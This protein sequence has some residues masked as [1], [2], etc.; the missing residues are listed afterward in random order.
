MA[1]LTWYCMCATTFSRETGELDEVAFRLFLQ[2]IVDAKLGVYLGSAG[3]GEGHAL[4]RD[5]LRRVYQIG[6]EVC[7]GKVP[8]H[9][10][11]P[12][13]HTS[14]AAREH[15]LI[16]VEAGV[17]VVHMYSLA[18]WHGMRPTDAE[19]TAYY[20]DLLSAIKHPVA[21]AVNPTMGYT[22]KPA[23]VAD[24]CHRYP[25]IVAV[26]LTG[27]PDTYLINLM[28]LIGRNMSYH[29]MLPGSLNAFLLG[30]NAL[31][32]SESNIIPKTYRS[33]LDLYQQKR[34]DELRPVYA[35][36]RRFNQYVNQWAPNNPRWLKMAMKVLKLPGGEGGMREPYRM[37][38][39]EELQKFTDGLL[40]LGIAEVEELARAAG[41]RMPG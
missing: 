21:F 6:V 33:Y 10:N 16:A 9:A 34:F 38:S 24:I 40:R 27:M 4:T 20:D 29:V 7:K 32:G 22:P 37:P 18:G 31:F 19:L 2:R 35:D 30:A 13:Q 12:E 15:A 26:K 1:D 39:K 25:Q 14:R 8:V 23:L 41:L 11:P 36:L 3:S 28:D 17:E 5:E